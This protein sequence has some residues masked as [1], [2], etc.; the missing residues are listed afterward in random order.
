MLFSTSLSLYIGVNGISCKLLRNEDESYEYKL[1]MQGRLIE[2]FF[3]SDSRDKKCIVK[4]AQVISIENLRH[5][6][7]FIK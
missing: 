6:I 3:V 4:I 7:I 2:P 1:K 5:P